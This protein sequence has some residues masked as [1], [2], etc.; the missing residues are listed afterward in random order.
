MAA[1]ILFVSHFRIV[2]ENLSKYGILFNWN[3]VQTYLDPFF[4]ILGTIAI[5]THAIIGL[6]LEIWV[7]GH[8]NEMRYIRIFNGATFLNI[9]GVVLLPSLLVFFGRP[10]FA[11]G[12]LLLMQAMMMWMKLISFAL[13]NRDLRRIHQEGSK[14]NPED[15]LKKLV[16]NGELVQYPLNLTIHNMY[17]FIMAPTLVY[18]MNYPRTAKIRW[19]WL[20]GK[21]VQFIFF[22]LLMVILVEQFIMPTI[23]NTIK[24]HLDKGTDLPYLLARLLKLAIPSL[25]VWLIMFYAFFHL[26]LNILGELLRFGDRAFYQDWWNSTTLGEYWRRWNLPVHNWLVRH[27]YHPI[28]RRGSPRPLSALIIFFISAVFHELLAS[29][30]LSMVRWHFFMGMLL[31]VPLIIV[32]ERW[33]KGHQMGNIFFWLFFCVIGQPMIMLLYYHDYMAAQAT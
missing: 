25:L 17:Y 28:R 6:K 12:G 15:V 13:V 5:Q 22:S 33:T 16:D 31:Q 20:M 3:T 8:L 18:Q 26:Y 27:V 11:T 9:L 29:I 32:T 1:L 10:S 4:L 23:K 24:Y 21:L 7:L 19:Y 14:S 30:P 2:I